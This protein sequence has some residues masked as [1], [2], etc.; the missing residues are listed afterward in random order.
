MSAAPSVRT[1]LDAVD[2][3]FRDSRHPSTS[4]HALHWHP[5][6][7]IADI[8]EYL[9]QVLSEPGDLVLDPF[10]GSGTT[11]YEALRLGRRAIQSDIN[12]ASIEVSVAKASLLDAQISREVFEQLERELFWPKLPISDHMQAHEANQRE[13]VQW[14]DQDT[15]CQLEAIWKLVRE[16]PQH[17]AR[18]IL[19]VLFADTLFACLST[20]GATTRA[21]LKRRHHWGWIADNVR[22]RA[23]VKHDAMRIFRE[24]LF[25]L[26]RILSFQGQPEAGDCLTLRQN[27]QQLALS[28]NSVDLVVTSPP[29][30]GMID[31]TL[32]NR[33][34]YMWRDWPLDHD[35]RYEIGA[36]YRRNSKNAVIDYTEAM[37][38]CVGEIHRVLKPGKFCAIVV[39]ASRKYPHVAHAVIDMFAQAMKKFWG[40]RSRV[41]RAR[42]VAERAGTT[43]EEFVCVFQ[44]Q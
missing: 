25:G 9:I 4:V 28:D 1:L 42:R 44:K 29:Y 38:A 13:L 35:R 17:M 31:Y 16:Q 41:P 39:G 23:A 11:A 37:L 33:V 26:M 12:R 32:A 27:A 22:P 2:W 15:L 21:G 7:F 10:C 3:D 8:P 40:E 18:D 34:Y 36:R 20:A 14:L 30:L 19:R 6:N 24:K 43:S 5:G